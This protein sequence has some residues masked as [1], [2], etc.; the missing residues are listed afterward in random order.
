L[1]H[2]WIKK[3][4]WLSPP[5]LEFP[6]VSAGARSLQIP[7]AMAVPVVPPASLVMVVVPVDV[8]VVTVGEGRLRR[9]RAEQNPDP[10]G[11]AD[12]ESLR[13]FLP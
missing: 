5:A 10:N 4:H 9:K 12:Q 2:A 1:G 8:A 13:G 6:G 11:E 3:G 7:T